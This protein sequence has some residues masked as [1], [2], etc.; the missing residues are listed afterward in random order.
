[1]KYFDMS[2]FECRGYQRG[3]G[4]CSGLPEN[5]MSD[6]LLNKLD[7]LREAVG[8]PIHVNCGYR[9]PSHNADVGGV[10]NSQHVLGT[11]AD[12]WCDNLSV[13]EL[14]DAAVNVGFDGIGRYYD[15]EFV[16]V[17]CRDAGESPN[18]YT[19]EG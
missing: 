18:G 19:W 11:A 2:E 6:V 3:E 7:E 5:G 17:D 16:H 14:A 12:I 9:C 4:C 1:M 10:S 15:Q 13:D 8:C